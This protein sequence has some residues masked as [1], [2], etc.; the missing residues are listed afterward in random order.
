MPEWTGADR[1]RRI[2]TEDKN[3]GWLTAPLPAGEPAD[4]NTSVAHPARVYDYWLGGKDNFA[5]DREA[6]DRVLAA[7]PGLRERVRA[8]R[9][10][11]V[12]AVRYL[13]AEAG[14]RQFLDVG[15]GI[16]ARKP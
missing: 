7:T 11:L 10:F 3:G 2:V 15:T 13:A 5:A 16:P 4:I 6:G 1:E 14:I 12:R 8:N 9:A